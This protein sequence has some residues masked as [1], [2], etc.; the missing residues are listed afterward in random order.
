MIPILKPYIKAY[1]ILL[2]YFF[3]IL[4]MLIGISD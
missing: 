1:L 2:P 3:V 4:M